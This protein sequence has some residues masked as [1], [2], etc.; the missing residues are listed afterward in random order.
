MMRT[1]FLRIAMLMSQIEQ[2]VL[3]FRECQESSPSG[4]IPFAPNTLKRLYMPSLPLAV[5]MDS[6]STN[7]L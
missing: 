3:V 1:P 7:V 5:R 6:T 4:N 2:E